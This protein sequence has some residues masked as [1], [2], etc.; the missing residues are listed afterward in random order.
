MF[1]RSKGKQAGLIFMTFKASISNMLLLEHAPIMKTTQAIFSFFSVY[2]TLG[3]GLNRVGCILV[4][5]ATVLS[6]H[7]LTKRDSCCC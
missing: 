4:T 6:C 2:L 7:S 3:T 5:L 1:Q